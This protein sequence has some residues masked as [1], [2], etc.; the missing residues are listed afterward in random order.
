MNDNNFSRR[1]FLKAGGALAAT[2]T[3]GACAGM[4]IGSGPRVVVVGGGYGGATC[5]KYIRKW[6]DGKIDVTLV[7]RNDKFISC[8]LS[9]LVIGGS[10][11]LSDLTV[12]YDNLSRL[13]GVKVVRD[14]A[15]SI[16]PAKKTVK[17]KSGTELAYDKL[18]KRMIAGF[19]RLD[20]RVDDLDQRMAAG[21]FLLDQRMTE[22]FSRLERKFDQVI[23]TQS[24]PTSTTSRRA[25]PSKRRR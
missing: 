1:D 17:L 20:R 13:H 24:R 4:A 9:N 23:D 14:E 8:P 18:G 5:A 10:K 3:L 19:S 22:G 16:D 11:E 25:R 12:G 2:G 15:V 7:E 21:F 6:S